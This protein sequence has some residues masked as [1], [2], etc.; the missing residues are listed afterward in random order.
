MGVIGSPHLPY[1]MNTILDKNRGFL[2]VVG[3]NKLLENFAQ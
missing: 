3:N 1:F 2:D